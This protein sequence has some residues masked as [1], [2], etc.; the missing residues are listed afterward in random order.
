MLLTAGYYAISNTF[1]INASGIVLRGVGNDTNGTVIF[2]T[3]TNGPD[4]GALKSQVQG[5]VVISG[6]YS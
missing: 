2:S 5:V 4:N 3:S 1:S 6:S